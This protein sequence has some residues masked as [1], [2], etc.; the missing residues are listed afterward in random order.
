MAGTP[1]A[2]HP[3]A[4]TGAD[5]AEAAD[6]LAGRLAD[7]APDVV[8]TY[9]EHGGYGHPDH[10]QAHRVTLAAVLALPPASRPTVYA[11]VTPR[12]WAEEDRAWL[13]DHVPP[14]GP[15]VP[16]PDAPYA[17][18]V[19]DDAL[20]THAVVDP[21]ALP[22]QVAAVRQHATQVTVYDGY[23]ALS[24]EIAA[25]LPG[26]E[27]YAVLDPETGRLRGRGAAR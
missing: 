20:V 11:V 12:T 15:T 5:V 16:G 19:V 13:R 9:D 25:R 1:S 24:N 2:D 21:A 14:D 6:L 17:P 4:F 23:Y 8:L 26:R 22:A 7:L 3:R 18:S 27:G 10:I